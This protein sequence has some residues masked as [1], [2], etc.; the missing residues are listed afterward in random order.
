MVSFAVPSDELVDRPEGQR[1]QVVLLR[2][3]TEVRPSERDGQPTLFC[4]WARQDIHLPARGS[5]VRL[6]LQRVRGNKSGGEVESGKADPVSATALFP[7]PLIPTLYTIAGFDVR[8]CIVP[9]AAL[10]AICG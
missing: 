5:D 9:E 2:R 8:I 6:T 10:S 1:L 3:V 7:V 4:R